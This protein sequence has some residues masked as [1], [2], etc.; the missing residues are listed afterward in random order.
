MNEQKT[1]TVAGVPVTV[2]VIGQELVVQVGR[3][4]PSA[5][6][7]LL[8]VNRLSG[9]AV[10]TVHVLG[11]GGRAGTGERWVAS[12]YPA[13]T[14]PAAAGC[15]HAPEPRKEPGTAAPEPGHATCRKEDV[16]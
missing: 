11:E 2:T 16:P 4:D 7:R 9:T 1:V 3:F 10:A 15:A 6:I 8:R 13:Q 12:I 5:A 14:G